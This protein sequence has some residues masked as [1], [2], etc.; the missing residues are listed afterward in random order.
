[1]PSIWLLNKIQQGEVDSLNALKVLLEK[2][3]IST[4]FIVTVGEMYLHKAAQ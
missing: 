4:D 2:G 3:E 1:M